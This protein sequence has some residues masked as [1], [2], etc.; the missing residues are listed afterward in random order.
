MA[1]SERA[2]ESKRVAESE[3][4]F[5]TSVLHEIRIEIA[6]EDLEALEEDREQR[7]PCTFIF[8]GRRLENVA[9]RLKG[10]GS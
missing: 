9:I 2:A 1:E 5:D 6:P 10:K 3:R 8:D 7:V 4:V